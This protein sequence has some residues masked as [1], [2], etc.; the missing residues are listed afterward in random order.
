MCLCFVLAGPSNAIV[1]EVKQVRCSSSSKQARFK[2]GGVAGK[3]EFLGC[4]C[5]EGRPDASSGK[6]I[7]N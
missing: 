5:W 7:E 6:I 3:F 1:A 2:T 4:S